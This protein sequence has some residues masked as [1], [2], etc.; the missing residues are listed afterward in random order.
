M[1]N[2]DIA[3][4]DTHTARLDEWLRRYDVVEDAVP[5]FATNGEGIIETETYGYDEREVLSR[6]EAMEKM[7]LAEARNVVENWEDGSELVDGLIYLMLTIDDDDNPIIR[8]AGKTSKYGRD[9]SSLSANL[10]NLE[11]NKSKFARFGS[12]Y[13]Y[14]IGELSVA[15]LGHHTDDTVNRSDPPETKY[16][17]WHD[18]LFIDGRQLQEPVYYWCQ[19]WETGDNGVHGLATDLKSLEY[20]I[21]EAAS[22]S[23]R[24]GGLLLNSEGARHD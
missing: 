9:G 24:H 2:T 22:M 7:V 10:K 17:D 3:D 23:S 13:A 5:L 21:I 18:A 12:G 8:Y 4:Q 14:H 20:Q 1:T 6:S 16:Q 15:A 11:T 19:A